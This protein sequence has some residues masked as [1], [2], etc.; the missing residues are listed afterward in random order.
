MTDAVEAY[1]RSRA[2]FPE[3]VANAVPGNELSPPYLRSDVTARVDAEAA[4]WLKAW[5]MP[6]PFFLTC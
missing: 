6:I 3:T 1:L 2:L 4:A 5:K